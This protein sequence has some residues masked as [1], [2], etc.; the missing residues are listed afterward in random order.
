MYFASTQDVLSVVNEKSKQPADIATRLLQV[1]IG[2]FVGYV[3]S[4]WCSLIP[5]SGAIFGHTVQT[6]SPKV[7]LTG[8]D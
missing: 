5:L 4:L 8:I 1:F 7:D 3:G 6:T 2:P